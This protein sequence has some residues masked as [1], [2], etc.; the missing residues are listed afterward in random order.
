MRTNSRDAVAEVNAS[1]SYTWAKGAPCAR[2]IWLIVFIATV[3]V[4]AAGAMGQTIDAGTPL[5]PG[6]AFVTRFSGTKAADGNEGNKVRVINP[7]GTVG[8]IVDLRSPQQPP[9]GQHWIDEPQRTPLKARDVGQ[10]FGVALDNASPPNIYVTATAAFGLH[11]TPGTT[12]WMQGMWGKDG[13]PG[14]IYKLDRDNNYRPTMFATVALDG[15]RNTGAALGNIAFDRANNQFVVSD[16]ETGMLHRIR[17]SDGRDLGRYD[18]GTQGRP[19]FFDVPRGKENS[20]PPLAFD[21]S[22]RARIKDCAAGQFDRNPEC[23][24]IAGTGR[25]I[26]GVGVRYDAGKNQSRVFYAVWSSPAFANVSWASE[27]DE[28][29][30]CGLVGG[31]WP[32]RRFRSDRCAPRVRFARLLRQAGGHCTF[33]A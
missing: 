23:W 20:L 24:N 15:R 30:Q 26:W 27:R 9:Q 16:L 13:D 2:P 31:P 21:P 5:R 10:I 8:S 22:S 14:T 17:A 3:A 6:E 12:D 28:A 19:R 18:H 11:H 25:R 1:S 33:G 7:D 29:K 32:G 4:F